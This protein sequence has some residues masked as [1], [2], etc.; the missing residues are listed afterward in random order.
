M[1]AVINR[2]R[3]V[4]DGTGG[5][6]IAKSGLSSEDLQHLGIS[7]CDGDVN[8]FD[9]VIAF[10]HYS[11]VIFGRSEDGRPHFTNIFDEVHS[12]LADTAGGLYHEWDKSMFFVLREVAR[13]SLKFY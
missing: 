8:G 6:L 7:F 9:D 5:N 10:V 4:I 12:L 3:G 13:I 2:G 1:R 11:S